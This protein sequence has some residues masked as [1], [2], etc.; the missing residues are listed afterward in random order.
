MAVDIN[1]LLLDPEF[2]DLGSCN[3]SIT[4]PAI[5]IGAPHVSDYILNFNLP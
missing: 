3:N 2:E 4:N 1:G 5:R